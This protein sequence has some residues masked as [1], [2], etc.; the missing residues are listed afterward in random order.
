MKTKPVKQTARTHF[1]QIPVAVVK[2]I[3]LERA[4]EKKTTET[5]NVIAEPPT[6]K[7]EPYSMPISSL[8]WTGH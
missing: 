8:S 1:E 3:A 7:T 6:R 5:G 2:K 4:P